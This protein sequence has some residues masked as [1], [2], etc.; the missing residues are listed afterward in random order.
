MNGQATLALGLILWVA[1]AAAQDTVVISANNSKGQISREGTIVDWKGSSLTISSNGREREVDNER[2][3]EVQTQWDKNYL[4]GKSSL[5]EHRFESAIAEFQL[6]VK[7]EKR[8]W[9]KRL[10]QARMLEALL[11]TQNHVEA[12]RQFLIITREDPQTRFFHLIPLSWTQSS[13]QTA[14]TVNVAKRLANSKDVIAQLI[15]ASWM[16]NDALDPKSRSRAKA[17]LETLANDIEPRIAQLATMQL[18]RFELMSVDESTIRSWE[19]RV[20]GFEATIRGG[21]RWLIAEAKNRLRKSDE[22]AIQFLSLPILHPEQHG[23][24]PQCLYQAGTI[25]QSNRPAESQIIF[26][27]LV[28]K[29]P[30]T[31]WAKQARQILNQK[32]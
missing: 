6:A 5:A 16:I 28:T 3:I 29:Y 4:A 18:W 27:E 12:I 26:N 15:A 32:Q 2:I 13:L 14:S 10:I 1:T 22:A 24:L 21:G 19:K 17:L 23:L 8:P 31:P 7:A 11:A 25:L 20:S 9:A 30:K